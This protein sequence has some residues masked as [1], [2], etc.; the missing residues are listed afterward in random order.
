MDAGL[1]LLSDV[2]VWSKY[3][4]YLPELERRESWDEIVDRLEMCLVKRYPM[5]KEEIPKNLM[6][7]RHKKVLP[8]MRMTQFSGAAVEANEVRGY[9]CSYR[10]AHDPKVFSETMFLLLSGSGVGYSVQKHH[11]EQLPTIK[12]TGS[13]KKFVVEDSIIGWAEAVRVL[14][15][16][17]FFGKSYPSFDYSQIRPKGSRLVTAGGKAPGP[18]PLRRCIDRLDDILRRKDV[19]SKLTTL[20][21]HDMLCHIANAV[22][23]GGIRRS[24]LISLFSHDDSDMINCKSG[25]WWV[26]NEQRGRCNN[27]AVLER[28]EITKKDFLDLWDKVKASGSGEPGFYWT[29]DKELGTN[30]CC[31]VGSTNILTK[32]G[33]KTIQSLVGKEDLVF[34]NKDG[35]PHRGL[36]WSNGLRKVVDIELSNGVGIRCTPDHIFMTEDGSCVLAKDLKG[37][38]L[39]TYG[40]NDVVYVTD[41]KEC[42]EKEEVFDFFIDDETHWG[43]VEGIIAH[44]CE[45][46]LKAYGLCNLTEINADNI[47]S[48]E[49]F[50]DRA[51]VAAFL[52]TL[53]AG[54]TDF[55]YLGREWRKNAEEEA[56]LGV[57]MTGIAS[58]AVLNLDMKEAVAIVKAENER[59]ADIIG[60]NRAKRLTCVKPAGTTSCVLGSSS[61]IHGWHS[62]YY[63]RTMRFN[64]S[65]SIVPFFYKEAPELIESDIMDPDNT[66]CIRIPVKAPSGAIYRDE[67]A[68]ELLERVSLVSRDWVKEGHVEGA[69]TNNV[70]ATISIR[71]GEWEEV[72]E[73]MWDNRDVYNGLSVLPYD[74]GTY[75]QAP[76]EAISKEEYDHYMSVLPQV[77]ITTITETDDNVQFGDIVACAGGQ[78]EI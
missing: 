11:V 72:G 74:G 36:V 56:L 15:Y 27:S 14:V 48:Q 77:D 57:G 73:W 6:M 54:F 64:R 1:N 38:I 26:E 65:E 52:G 12:K 4:K 5:L 9:N 71:D 29:N 78:C 43:V 69:N 55:H 16:S 47:E 2:T 33:Y 22:L 20:E 32:E 3:A 24:A 67:T 70:S 41:I 60:I 10:P 58:G 40:K 62:Q 46:S 37:K 30:P 18:E 63:L 23:A 13:P 59:V 51:R 17:Y 28:G 49:D 66:V 31:F 76:F 42:G 45:I 21:C 19:G 61:G 39:K 25:E 7:M 34:I 53:Q 35:H 75:V 68:L 50:N 8:S 44:N